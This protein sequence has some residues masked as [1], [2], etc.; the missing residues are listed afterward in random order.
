MM[1]LKN[2]QALNLSQ[3]DA[4]YPTGEVYY[5]SNRYGNSDLLHNKPFM[6]RSDLVKIREVKHY[7]TQPGCNVF[8]MIDIDLTHWVHLLSKQKDPLFTKTIVYKIKIQNRSTFWRYYVVDTKKRL[9][10]LLTILSKEDGSYFTAVKAST[11]FPNTYC[12]ESTMAMELCDQYDR[13][14]SLCKLDKSTEEHT[15][16][17]LEKLPYPTYDSLKKDKTN[18]K[19]S[20][21]I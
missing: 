1:I 16:I 7:P 11:E 18:K 17:V 12:A 3:L 9:N 8:A 21:V 4:G 20:I 10:G 2:N 19:N 6:S 14:F 13:S 5:L 15:T